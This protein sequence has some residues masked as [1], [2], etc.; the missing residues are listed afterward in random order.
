MKLQCYKEACKKVRRKQIEA[1][2]KLPSD[3]SLSDSDESDDENF[4]AKLR[5][6]QESTTFSASLIG[7]EEEKEVDQ[8]E[9]LKQILL[10]PDGEIVKPQS[11]DDLSEPTRVFGPSWVRPTKVVK[12]IVRHI[13]QDGAECTTV[14]YIIAPEEVARVQNAA[15]RVIRRQQESQQQKQPAV[16]VEKKYNGSD[17]SGM[18][19]NFRGIYDKVEKLAKER[20]EKG[21]VG[22]RAVRAAKLAASQSCTISNRHPKVELNARLEKIIVDMW[23]LPKALPFRFPPNEIPGYLALISDPICLLDIRKKLGTYS[24][25]T[26]NIIEALQL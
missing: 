17:F 7:A 26:F 3:D 19:I 18:K 16:L 24:V 5:K 23:T 4:V 22:E 1:L 6:E 8:L 12:R 21:N 2:S 20:S 9:E 14:S 13:Q 10:A 15:K 11:S 25:K